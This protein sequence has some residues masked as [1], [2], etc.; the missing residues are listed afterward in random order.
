[1]I[2]TT[3]FSAALALG[4]WLLDHLLALFPLGLPPYATSK[5][6]AQWHE[7]F[8][9]EIHNEYMIFTALFASA[10]VFGYS[11]QGASPGVLVG[12]KPGR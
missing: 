7:G 4:P 11:G 10:L 1:M 2:L 3:H 6:R 12:I 8:S 9:S 5:H